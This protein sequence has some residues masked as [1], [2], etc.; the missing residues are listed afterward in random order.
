[1]FYLYMFYILC[2]ESNESRA[3]WR[4]MWGEGLDIVAL[5]ALFP[6]CTG[7]ALGSS[8]RLIIPWINPGH[9]SRC[10]QAH[11]EWEL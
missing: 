4:V 11:F 10:A 6:H 1:M 9:S 8:W 5:L 3:E 7:G 2:A